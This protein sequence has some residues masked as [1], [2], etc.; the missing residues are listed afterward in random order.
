MRRVVFAAVPSIQILDLTAAY[1]VFAR[2]GGYRVELVSNDPK[3]L[4]ESSCGLTLRGAGD[5][6]KVRGPVDT[7]LVPGGEGAEEI[8][9]LT[10]PDGGQAAGVS[11]LSRKLSALGCP[12]N[13]DNAVS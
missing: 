6:R 3:G 11:T 5:Y 10:I 9:T 7:L 8:D 2:C 1:E 4:V 12:V 13:Q